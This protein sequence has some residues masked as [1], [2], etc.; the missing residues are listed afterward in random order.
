MVCKK[1]VMCYFL[2]CIF[3]AKRL[4]YDRISKYMVEKRKK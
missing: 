3:E 2:S 1:K 4:K